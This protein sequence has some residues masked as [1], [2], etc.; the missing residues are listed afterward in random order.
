MKVLLISPLPALDPPCG[1][2]TYTQMLLAHPPKGVQYV[3][4]AEALGDRS[5]VEHAT[6]RRF[7]QEPLLTAC[8]K[9]VNLARSHRML[10]WEPFRFFSV[11]PRVYDVVHLHMFSARFFNPS[12]PLVVSNAAPL[13]YLYVKARGYSGSRTQ[14]IEWAERAIAWAMGVNHVSYLLPQ[15]S[16]V[17]AFT[18]IL[19]D[20]YVNRRILPANRVDV[21]PIYLP[22][23]VKVSEQ[24]SNP[25]TVGFVAKDFE[26]KGGP[27]LLKAFSMVRA[28]RP[29][30]RLVI[31]G[32]PPQVTAIEAARQGI[33]WKPYVDREILLRELIPS[34][35]VLAYPTTIDGQPLVVMESMAAGVAIATSDYQALPEMVDHGRAGLVSRVGDAGMLASNILRLL[36]PETNKIFRRAA[37]KRFETYFSADSV[38]PRLR[39]S[40]DLAASS[41]LRNVA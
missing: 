41:P 14:S 35:D 34:F 10:F 27:T 37:R 33:E 17:I 31:V 2:V 8:N 11:R 6:R 25:Q 1:D 39:E 5:L 18:E 21:V 4:Y 36:D 13:R 12:C 28:R 26:A 3:T 16:R 20:W 22:D 15:A 7:R 38:Q 19:K 29:D 40:Y 24:R 23:R 32:C 9:L 30:A